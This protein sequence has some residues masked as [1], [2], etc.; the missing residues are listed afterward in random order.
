MRLINRD[1]LFYDEII[2][3]G[4]HFYEWE[5]KL[6]IKKNS[7]KQKDFFVKICSS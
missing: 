5:T 1:K 7:S 6:I 4:L 2:K 3:L